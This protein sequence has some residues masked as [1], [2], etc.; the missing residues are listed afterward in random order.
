MSI[1]K[2]MQHLASDTHDKMPLA[3]RIH[4]LSIVIRTFTIIRGGGCGAPSPIDKNCSCRCIY[5][6]EHTA[7]IHTKR[8]IA[9]D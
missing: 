9:R 6:L 8:G 7:A 3:P 1:A 5:T 4:N 2:A